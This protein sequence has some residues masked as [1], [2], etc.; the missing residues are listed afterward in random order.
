VVE[1]FF[2]SIDWTTVAMVIGVLTSVIAADG[3]TYKGRDMFSCKRPHCTALVVV[4]ALAGSFG[5]NA[6]T[7]TFF[8]V[9]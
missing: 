5:A 4:A 7:S 9:P 3:A 6:T 1:S 8:F 2:L